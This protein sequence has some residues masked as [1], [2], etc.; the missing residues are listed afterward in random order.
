MN[1]RT[2]FRIRKAWQE[3]AT[4]LGFEFIA[5]FAISANEGKTKYLGL[6]PKFGSEKG[7]VLIFESGTGSKKERGLAEAAGYGWSVMNNGDYNEFKSSYFEAVLRDWEWFGSALE[8]PAF[9]KRKPNQAAQTRS[10]T[11][12]V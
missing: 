11:R 12:P 6:V 4:A 7:T 8:M 5:P 2:S 9:L 10:L 1:P 3:A